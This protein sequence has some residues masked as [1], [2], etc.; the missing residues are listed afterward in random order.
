MEGSDGKDV[1]G[2]RVFKVAGAE[3]DSGP[4]TVK[5]GGSLVAFLV[6]KR[7]ALSATSLHTAACPLVSEE[8]VSMT[9]ELACSTD[10]ASCL[11]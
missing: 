8:L 7:L 3:V 1:L 6:H 10:A 5:E 2:A 4:T 11:P 9:H